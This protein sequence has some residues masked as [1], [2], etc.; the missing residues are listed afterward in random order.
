M[1]AGLRKELDHEISR[2][3]G[4]GLPDA[5]AVAAAQASDVVPSVQNRV[6][7]LES[8]LVGPQKSLRFEC[9]MLQRSISQ[10]AR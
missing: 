5:A 7:S 6:Y 8:R 10:I 3:A 1:S 4:A 9:C 2:S